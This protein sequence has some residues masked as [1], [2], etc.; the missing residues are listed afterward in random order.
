MSAYVCLLYLCSAQ[1]SL[2]ENTQL[3]RQ[4]KNS[5]LLSDGELDE[6]METAL[7]S[8]GFYVNVLCDR[9]TIRGFIIFFPRNKRTFIEM[10]NL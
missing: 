4:Y 7:I 6:T 5:Y 9:Y 3:F 2:A 10:F 8:L 1:V